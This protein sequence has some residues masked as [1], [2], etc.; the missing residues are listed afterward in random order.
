VKDVLLLDVTSLS[1]GIETRGGV[2][3]RLIKRN[4]SIPTQ[5]RRTVSTSIDNQKSVEIKVLQGEREFASD[6]R[7]LGSFILDGIPPAP[8][9]TPQ[10]EVCFDIDANG[11]VSVSAH[12]KD[13]GRKQTIT[14]ASSSGLSMDQ[15]DRMVLEARLHAAE[16]KQRREVAEE[17]NLA[18]SVAY[19]IEKSIIQLDKKISEAVKRDLQTKISGVRATFMTNDAQRIKAAR[20][21]L[22][23]SFHKV[24]A[25]I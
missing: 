4:T 12:D 2:F 7:L 24:K 6:N 3:S 5:V 1:L 20:K 13:T 11:I 23:Q 9:G 17:R 10:I 15:I 21:A 19:R 25:R 14:I 16:D 18:D 22:E 8:R